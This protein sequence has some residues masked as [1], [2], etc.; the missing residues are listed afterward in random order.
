LAFGDVVCASGTYADLEADGSCHIDIS[1]TESLDFSNFTFTQAGMGTNTAANVGITVLDPG[2]SILGNVYGFL[3]DPGEGVSGANQSEDILLTYTIT[4]IGT[5]ITSVDL[6]ENATAT[7]SGV[8]E[9][10]ETLGVVPMQ[11]VSTGAKPTTWRSRG[12]PR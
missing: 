3:I 8:G 1:A 10:D 4:A 7:G 6:D 2:S 9:V 5:S 12:R 11:V